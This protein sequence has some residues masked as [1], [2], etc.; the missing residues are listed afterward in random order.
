MS[1]GGSR[2]TTKFKTNIF[3]TK[4]NRKSETFVTESYTPDSKG[5]LDTPPVFLKTLKITVKN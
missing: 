1:R 2:S 5:V 4:G 3:A